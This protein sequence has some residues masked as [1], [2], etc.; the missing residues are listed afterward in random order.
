MGHQNEID[1]DYDNSAPSGEVK[2]WAREMIRHI[3]QQRGTL[4]LI[5]LGFYGTQPGVP[6]HDDPKGDP[7]GKLRYDA[8]IAAEL[9]AE[10]DF[11]SMHYF[12]SERCFESDVRQLQS[13]V[14]DKPIV[15]EEFCMHTLAKPD[16]PCSSFPDPC[17]DPHF[18][19]QQQAFYNAL[20]SVSEAFRVAGYFFWTLTDFSS[21]YPPGAQQSHHCQGILR[22][23]VTSVCEV[24][25]SIDY[26]EKP[27]AEA[28]RSHFKPAVRYIEHFNSWVD[29]KTDEP[30]PGW[31]A[32]HGIDGA[33]LRGFNPDAPQDTLWSRTYGRVAISKWVQP[34][35][36]HVGRAT[37]PT[38]V[39]VDVDS[40]PFLSGEVSAYAV[41]KPP[42]NG[43]R[44]AD[45]YIGVEEEGGSTNSAGDDHPRR[46]A[47]KAF[48]GRSARGA[49]LEWKS[50]VPGYPR[51]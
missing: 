37:S 51:A 13:L 38:L 36:A 50:Y 10:V 9:A 30:P 15:L 2:A 18:E 45:L 27:A 47:T 29:P 8:N 28:V 3:R 49:R 22:N 7:T 19:F 31:T 35:A 4:N 14:A 6:C 39:Q 17:D 24:L 23:A 48:H 42:G 41:R 34:G 21:I 11:V 1:R 43:G 40:Y 46:H 44:D 16:S 12:L 5:T 20:L 33:L 26:S 32:N 25:N